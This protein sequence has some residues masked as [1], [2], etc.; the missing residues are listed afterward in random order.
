MQDG[1]IKKYDWILVVVVVITLL[2]SVLYLG[3][4][5]KFWFEDDPGV[6]AT[7]RTISNPLEIFYNPDI[8]RAF[9]TG[10]AVVPMQLLSYWF[11]IKFFGVSP[12]AAN[13]HSV[14]SLTLTTALLYVIFRR[15]T[16]DR[17]G[18]A[19]V[20]LLWICLPSTIAVHYFIS[21]RHYVEGFGWSLFSCWL[22]LR[23]CSLPDKQKSYFKIIAICACVLAA[24]L[25]KEIYV[26]TLPSFV[27]CY[28][29]SK[30][31]YVL[32]A[33]QIII[34]VAYI[35][36]RFLLIGGVGKY[37][38]GLADGITYLK[39][40]KILP[41][42]LTANNGGY[43]ILGGAAIGCAWLLV[44]RFHEVKRVMFMA[45]LLIVTALVPLYPTSSK[46]LKAFTIPGTWYRATFI[47][48]TLIFLSAGYLLLQFT[49]RLHQAICLYIFMIILIP[50]TQITR[51]YWNYR[52]FNAENEAR[53]YLNNPDKLLLSE[54]RAAWYLPGID[55]L[56]GVS[57]PH[58]ISYQYLEGD[59]ARK[60]IQQ[61]PTIW[62][63]EDGMPIPDQQLYW[64]VR[65]KNY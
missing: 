3:V 14:I 43:I 27:F 19:C 7:V 8:M 47:L 5:D 15:I 37:P 16:G 10:A 60:M 1:V 48:D 23:L 57:R 63:V 29:I 51:E 65:L 42:T 35:C 24:M 2:F 46:V 64:E 52:L 53:F 25:S 56:Y 30:K 41:Y 20:S 31:Q 28:S 9:G 33:S 55:K 44:T 6:Y 11:D 13:L 26:T 61:F 36:Y 49:S 50:G 18:S 4:V 58:Y 12:F 34:V 32:G 45:I 21:A 40:L 54:E 62:R 22:V 59:H 38:G 39:Y 17:V